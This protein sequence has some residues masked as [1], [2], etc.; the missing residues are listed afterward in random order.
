L[1][2]GQLCY[3]TS[4][5]TGDDATHP[6][7]SQISIRTETETSAEPY[8]DIWSAAY[9]EAVDSLEHETRLAILKGENV[10][11]L[12]KQL[13]EIDK[14]ATDESVFMRGVKYLHSLQ[15]P[16]KKFKLALDISA[17][18]SKFEPTTATV[19]GAVQTV[20]AVRCFH[21]LHTSCC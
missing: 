21:L 13:E 4:S 10:T 5:S 9:R 20:T 6:Q 1:G 12:F 16:L 19:F 18:I 7:A 3:E 8:L 14:E 2:Q 15:V 11:Q 17:P